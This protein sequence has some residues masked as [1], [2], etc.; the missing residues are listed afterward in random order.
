MTGSAEGTSCMRYTRSNQMT[1]DVTDD[2][3]IIL[4][5]SGAQL[6]TLNAVGTILWEYLDEP[7]TSN[8]LVEH[9]S[10][11]FSEVSRDDIRVDVDDFL[12]SLVDQRLLTPQRDET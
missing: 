6:I 11:R 9:L 4:D 7:R 1:W 3:A 12:E 2:R 8:E 5:A 10:D